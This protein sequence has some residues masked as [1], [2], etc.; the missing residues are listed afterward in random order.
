M[1]VLLEDVWVDAWV[2]WCSVLG[3]V[4]AADFGCLGR[5]GGGHCFGL[6]WVGTV[7]H[8]ILVYMEHDLRLLGR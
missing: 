7:K 8:L 3:G 4:P 1:V 6:V 5:D 2:V